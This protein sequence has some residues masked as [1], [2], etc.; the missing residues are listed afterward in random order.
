MTQQV[1]AG[2][3]DSLAAAEESEEGRGGSR[4][5]GRI[6][7]ARVHDFARGEALPRTTVQALEGVYSSFA[8]AAAITLSAYLHTPFQ[9]SML[10]LDQLTYD[11]FV[12]SVPDP[13][14]IAVFE[15]K[16]LPGKAILEVNPAIGFWIVD[17]MLGGEGEILKTPRP[18][19]HMER[20]LIEGALS[21]MLVELGA[22]CKDLIP[23]EPELVEIV[24]SARAAEIAKPTDAVAVASFEATVS[25]L[26]TMASICLPVIALKLGRAGGRGSH[27][28]AA[29]TDP[30]ALR[31]RL[32][33]ALMPLPV[34]CV[35]RLGRARLSAAELRALEEGDVLPL[36]RC[37]A[38]GLEMAVGG[39]PK[40]CCRP[41]AS[42]DRLVVEITGEN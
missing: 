12:R 30:R 16:P 14:V 5:G 27:D 8:R 37:V 24:E 4:Q 6:H 7:E 18:L 21:R 17:H 19:T 29:A 34:A 35:V 33:A 28:D 15:I 9:M 2:L 10:S 42:E 36:D 3:L 20:A 1:L 38:E 40:L 32:A 22:A 26:T 31:R 41:A 25:S 39:R 11:Q 13:T 23:M